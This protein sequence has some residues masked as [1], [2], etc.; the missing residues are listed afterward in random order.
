MTKKKRNII[1]LLL[2]CIVVVLPV[3]W[4][5]FFSYDST[6]ADGRYYVQNSKEYPDAYIEVKDGKAQFFQV[7]LNFYYK[8]WVVDNYTAYENLHN[9]EMTEE[10]K[11]ELSESV[12]LNA[13]FCEKETEI[14][15]SVFLEVEKDVYAYSFGRISPVN[16]MGFLYDAR[17]IK[18]TI[19]LEEQVALE[20]KK[21]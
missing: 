9:G 19:Q 6:V 7:D 14:D 2:C 5:V 8:E 4:L 13:L 21:G 15:K 18:I 17:K 3:I 20:F 12:D 16:Y 10:E 1:I 11:K